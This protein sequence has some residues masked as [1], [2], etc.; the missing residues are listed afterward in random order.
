M[1]CAQRVHQRTRLP[2]S[3]QGDSAAC[4]QARST[5]NLEHTNRDP[6]AHLKDHRGVHDP[7]HSAACLQARS[8]FHLEHTNRVPNAHLKDH[9]GVHDPRH[10]VRPRRLTR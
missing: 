7:R 4:L 6:D 10:Q 9:R 1:H 8:T 2:T 3:K 5:F